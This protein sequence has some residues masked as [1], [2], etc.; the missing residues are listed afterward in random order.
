MT[1][2]RETVGWSYW[3]PD[4]GQEWSDQHPIESGEVPDA[5]DIEAMTLEQF[6]DAYPVVADGWMQDGSW[7]P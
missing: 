5:T 4:A 2:K 7:A 3:N 1:S 6:D